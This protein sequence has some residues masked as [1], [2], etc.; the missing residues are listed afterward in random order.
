MRLL[1]L[2]LSGFRG[3]AEPQTFNFDGDAVI[4]VGANGQGK[5]SL[6]DGVLWAL[7]GRIPRLGG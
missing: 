3:F 2:K 6:F 1:S 7:C 4:V 5:T